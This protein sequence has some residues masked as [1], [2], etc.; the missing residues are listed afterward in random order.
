[1]VGLS[2]AYD[3]GFEDGQRNQV[4]SERQEHRENYKH[5]TFGI[6]GQHLAGQVTST[7]MIP[8]LPTEIHFNT[9]R[10]D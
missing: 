8:Y 4:V 2:K 6:Y 3:E 5:F 9:R 1:M 7:K 10:C